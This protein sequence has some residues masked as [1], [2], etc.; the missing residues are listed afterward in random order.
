MDAKIDYLSWTIMVNA[1]DG[2]GASRQQD[3]AIDALWQRHPAAAAWFET[4][5]T[6]KDGGARGHYGLSLFNERLF[7]A[8]R[9]GGQANHVLVEMPGTACQTARDDGVLDTILTQAA[10]R[11]TRLDLAVDFPGGCSPAEFVAAGYNERF[12]SHASIVSEQGT[13]EYVGSMKSERYARVYRYEPP[14]PRAGV[15]RVESVLRSGFAKSAAG[16]LLSSPLS[17]LVAMVGN[18]FGWQSSLWTPGDVTDGRLKATRADRHEPGRVR[19]LHQVCIPALVKAHDQGLIDLREVCA[20]ML[21]N[22]SDR[23]AFDRMAV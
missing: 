19:W 14:H 20:L 10:D 6:W 11:L 17:T 18:S 4:L 22:V 2:A 1:S 23:A 21:E 12:K 7:I 16:V 9:F 3:I 13:T 15:L 8:V 5:S